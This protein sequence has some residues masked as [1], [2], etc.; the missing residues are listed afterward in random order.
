[1]ADYATSVIAV[2]GCR[3][4][5]MRGGAGDPLIYLHG[6]SGAAWLPFL[7]TLTQKYDVIAPEHPG[8]GESDTPAWLDNIHDLAYFYLDL[9]AELKLSGAHLVG[10]SLGG[11]IA[12][13]LAVRSTARLASLT[14]SDAAGLHV[15]GV[16]QMDSFLCTDEQRLRQFFYDPKKAEEMIARVLRPDAEDIALKNRA[17]VAKLVWQPR[18]HDPNLGKWLHRIDVPTLLIW[19]DHDRLFTKEH[20]L[21]YQ[22]AIPGSKLVMIPKCGHVPQIEKPDDFVAALETFLGARKKAA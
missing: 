6:A 18:D 3:I 20:A 5:L 2:R 15:P 19:G 7:Q 21:A 4:R 9:M 14:L 12:A 17:I 10:N 1:M 16:K 22:K 13:E 11:W 8:F